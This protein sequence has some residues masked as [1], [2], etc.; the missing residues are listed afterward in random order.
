MNGI[1]RICPIRFKALTKIPVFHG[2]FPWYQELAGLAHNYDNVI[3][4]LCWLPLISTRAAESALHEFIDVARSSEI[5]TWG[6]DNWISE[7]SFGASL[8]LRHVL[9]K[10]L[11]D[12]VGDGYWNLKDAERLME[13]VM[14]K[15]AK[16]IYMK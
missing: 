7:E 12:R 16:Q 9:A 11:A 1:G 14:Y 8:A 13:K 4:D 10:V 5:I 3:L 6:G 2:G 15:N